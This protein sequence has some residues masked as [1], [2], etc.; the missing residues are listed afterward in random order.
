MKSN[1]IYPNV[2]DK[3]YLSQRTGNSC[4]DMVKEP[5]TVISVMPRKI[6]V[7]ACKLIFNGKRYFNTLPDDIQDDLNG[8]LL[9][10]HWSEKNQKW[11]IDQYHTGYPSYAFFGKWEYQPYLD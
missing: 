8:K 2:G 6:L 10:L 9:E 4:V 7:R 1:P 3:L 5:Y 11:Q